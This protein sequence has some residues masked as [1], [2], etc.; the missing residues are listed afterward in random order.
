[1][2]I[3]LSLVLLV[4]LSL[5]AFG[6]T[7]QVVPEARLRAVVQD[8]LLKKSQGIDAEVK[9]KKISL[10]GDLKLPAGEV[11]FEV[12][13]PERW[14]GWGSASLAVVV[15]VDDQVKRNLTVLTE[16]E[17]L[18][19]MVVANRTLERGE[20]VQAA[21]VSL[22]KRDLGKVSGRFCRT[23]SEVVG[24]R[25]KNA[26]RGNLPVRGDYL[27]RVPLVKSGQL[28]TI[29]AENEVIRLTASGR[30]KGSGAAGDTIAVQN[31]NSQKEIAARVIDASTVRVD[32]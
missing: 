23:P 14:E 12:I 27:E 2:R 22:A 28:V 10:P 11:S 19:E 3:V 17:A 5:P 6:D 9:V 29:V 31:L 16:V 1:M 25:V 18:A 21:D 32:F 13:A 26:I 4:A 8:F 24:M 15:R 20:V 7:L 30:A